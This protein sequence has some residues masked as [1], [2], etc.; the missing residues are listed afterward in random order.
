M[1]Q[2]TV[3]N[4]YGRGALVLF[5]WAD[6][7]YQSNMGSDNA[8]RLRRRWRGFEGLMKTAIVLIVGFFIGYY[9]VKNQPQLLA[10]V[11]L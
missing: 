9:L 5:L 8:P 7:P 4:R 11:G 6:Y 3:C 2:S 1:G 10:Q